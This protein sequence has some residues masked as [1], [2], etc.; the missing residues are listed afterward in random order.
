MWKKGARVGGVKKERERDGPGNLGFH[1]CAEGGYGFVVLAD[2][3]HLCAGHEPV[4]SLIRERKGEEQ[5]TCQI[6]G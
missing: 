3:V 2:V 1:A 5:R 6:L 4:N